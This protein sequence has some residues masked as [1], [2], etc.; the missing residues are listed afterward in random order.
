MKIT[1]NI[2]ADNSAFDRRLT[3]IAGPCSAETEAQTLRAARE[4]AALGRAHYFRA[5]VWKPRTRPGAFEGAGAEALPWL[6]R[7][8]RETGLRIAV[9][10]ATPEHAEACLKAGVDAL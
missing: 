4:V 5:G 7:A 1:A 10:A 3:L 9:E 8:R 2:G 6:V